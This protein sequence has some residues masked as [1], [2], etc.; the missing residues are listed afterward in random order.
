MNIDLFYLKDCLVSH[1]HHHISSRNERKATLTPFTSNKAVHH[2]IFVVSVHNYSS[3]H[4]KR[5]RVNNNYK[6]DGANVDT[7]NHVES[8]SQRI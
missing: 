3:L 7:S 6:V 5:P 8:S 2:Q 1:K 4:V